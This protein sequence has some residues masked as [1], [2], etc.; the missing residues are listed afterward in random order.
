M[1]TISGLVA[2]IMWGALALLGT[3]TKEIPAFQLLSMCFF[4]SAFIVIVKR[5]FT[6]Q[7][8]LR[9]P[10]LSLNQWLLGTIGLF[11][12]H[13]MF[14]MA[15]KHAPAIEVSLI[16]YLW[17]MLLAVFVATK[18]A[19]INALIGSTV[20]FV[21]ICFILLGD[22]QLALNPQY[23]L[24]YA[25]AISCAILWASYSWYLTK[26]DN[27]VDDIGWLSLAVAILSLIA[28]VVLEQSNWQLGLNQW[29]GIIALGLGP[30][31]GAFYL[32]D[33][34]LKHGN[35][36]LL[37]SLS[38]CAPLISAVALAFAGFNEW[39]NNIL[40]ALSLIIV[41]AL[42][43]NKAQLQAKLSQRFGEQRSRTLHN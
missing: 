32:W 24:G 29:L 28:H 5:F 34:G 39:S 15:L 2:I 42:I 19:L 43:A 30:V 6:K 37:A 10:T 33:I 26:S 9:G 31:G 16:V 11:G 12:F 4:I 13:F 1:A 22:G 40:I 36:N 27:E 23:L 3:T 25:L 14:F 18:A 38:F 8:L 35:K 20:G 41:G 17:P 7:P 21:G